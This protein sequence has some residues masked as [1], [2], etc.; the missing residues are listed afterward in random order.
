MYRLATC[1]KSGLVCDN[2]GHCADG[3]HCHCLHGWTGITCNGR[4]SNEINSSYSH[5]YKIFVIGKCPGFT[6]LIC[7]STTCPAV[8]SAPVCEC[9][10]HAKGNDCSGG[11]IFDSF[12]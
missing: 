9:P 4:T 10:G 2:G 8:G 1:E 7:Y 3:K 5:I 11:K 6:D 12:S